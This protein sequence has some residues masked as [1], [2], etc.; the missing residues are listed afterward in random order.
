MRKIGHSALTPLASSQTRSLA[1]ELLD[2]IVPSEVD[3]R[4]LV[5]SYPKISLTVATLGGLWLGK[6]HGRRLVS[7]ASNLAAD[8]VSEGFNEFFGRKVL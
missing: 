6:T 8:T 2:E 7:G 4:Q 1:D 5:V 3:W